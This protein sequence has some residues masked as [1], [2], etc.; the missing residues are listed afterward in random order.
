MSRPLFATKR[1]GY[2]GGNG[3]ADIRQ[4]VH[5]IPLAWYRLVVIMLP[6][7]G[8]DESL[9]HS[10]AGIAG[11][12]SSQAN[13]DFL[14]TTPNGIGHQLSRAVA[15]SNE[16]ITFRL[17]QQ[18]ET[19]GLSYLHDSQSLLQQVP[20]NDG[21]PQRVAHRNGD[22]FTTNGRMDGF[23][24]SLPAVTDFHRQHLGISRHRPDAFRCR[25]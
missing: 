16:W 2:V 13:N 11:G 5:T 18:G 19:T 7:K 20:G 6:R 24:E 17:G 10:Y 25:R 21:T 1:V 22:Q 23:E 14:G 9:Q 8:I 15:C 3:E 4:S 12:T